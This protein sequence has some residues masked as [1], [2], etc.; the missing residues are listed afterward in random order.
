MEWEF[1]EG[2][3]GSGEGEGVKGFTIAIRSN[4][5]VEHGMS[6]NNKHLP[7]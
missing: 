4:P 5:L 3:R 6:H 1:D 2:A 7:V